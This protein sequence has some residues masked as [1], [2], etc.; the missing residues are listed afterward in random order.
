[1]TK[2]ERK[3]LKDLEEKRFVESI[4]GQKIDGKTKGKFRLTKIWKE[5]RKFMRDKFKVD[6]L[7]H[8]KLNKTFNLHHMKFNPRFYTELNEKHFRCYNSNTHDVLHW[9]VSETIKDPTFMQRITDEV[10]LHIQL[11][12]RKDVKDFLKNI[13]IV[14]FKTIHDYLFR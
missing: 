10:N 2:E 12:E 7:T 13:L 9:L 11:N 4:K 5:F 8:R 14:I 6:Y 1:M 3:Y